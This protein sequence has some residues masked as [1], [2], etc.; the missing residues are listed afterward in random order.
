MNVLSMSGQSVTLSKHNPSPLLLN[1][2]G[3]FM[4]VFSGRFE[5]EVFV[6]LSDCVR[7]GL[8]KIAFNDGAKMVP[9]GIPQ[10]SSP[11]MVSLSDTTA[12]ICRQSTMVETNA[13]KVVEPEDLGR[14]LVMVRQVTPDLFGPPATS[15]WFQDPFYHSKHSLLSPINCFRRIEIGNGPEIYVKGTL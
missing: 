4:Q 14:Q 6:T 7:G 13:R 8:R 11:S 10:W 2:A 3:S 12:I 15:T 5:L 1:K 9:K